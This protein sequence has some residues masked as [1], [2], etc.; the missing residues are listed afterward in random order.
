MPRMPRL[1]SIGRP[2]LLVGVAVVVLVLV[3][4]SLKLVKR[5]GE[6]AAE[7]ADTV[8]QQIGSASDLQAQASL[9]T[10]LMAARTASME[11][12]SYL[13]AGPDQL[14][15]AEPALQY[16]I[17]DSTGPKVVSI[18]ATETDWAAAVRSDSGACLTIMAS[19]GTGS[20][21]SGPCTGS[22]AMAAA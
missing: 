1:P 21:Q 20:V 12:G 7:H 14:A 6:A 15:E 8:V 16:V 3:G 5:G 17:G 22:A 11:S 18:A 2:V 9:N 19:G 13:D 10:A 4:G